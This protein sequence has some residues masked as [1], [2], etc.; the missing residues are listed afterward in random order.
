MCGRARHMRLD[1]GDLGLERF[2]PRVELLDRDGVEILSYKFDQRVA[3][4]AREEFL[5][6][7]C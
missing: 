1:P 4:F 7:H 3:G 2:D 5:E 6:V